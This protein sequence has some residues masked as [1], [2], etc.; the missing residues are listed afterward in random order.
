MPRVVGSCAFRGNRSRAAV[1]WNRSLPFERHSQRSSIR[2]LYHF[3]NI[4]T[5]SRLPGGRFFLF[6][7]GGHRLIWEGEKSLQVQAAQAPMRGTRKLVRR[8]ARD[9]PQADKADGLYPRGPPLVREEFVY[10]PRR[11]PPRP[12]REDHG[13]GPGHD[14]AASPHPVTGGSARLLIRNEG[15]VTGDLQPLGAR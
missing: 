13:R 1:V 7:I 4:R 6:L 8:S 9:A 12:H 14:I 11:L 10:R 15:A 3:A 5:D 2:W